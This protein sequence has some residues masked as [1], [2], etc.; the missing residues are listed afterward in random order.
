VTAPLVTVAVPVYNHAPYIEQCLDSILASS[1]TELELIIIDDASPDDS[2]A[3][4]GAW[5]DKQSRPNLTFVQH[6][7]NCGVVSTL[8]EAARLA[9]GEFFCPLASDD[10]MLPDGIRDRVAY[11][12]QHP[13]KLAV[14]ADCRVID[15]TGSPLHQS[16]IEG[17]FAEAGMRKSLLAWDDL[18]P[19]QI[20]FS[21]AVAGP[22][23]MCRRQMWEIVGPYDEQLWVEDWDMYLRL[24]ARGALGFVDATV[25]KYRVHGQ[26]M[27]GG[28]RQRTL[29][30]IAQT[31]RKHAAQFRGIQ[32]LRLLATYYHHR[33]AKSRFRR[34]LDRLLKRL[35]T[36]YTDRA[37]RRL[38]S[39]HPGGRG[40][41]RAET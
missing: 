10:L 26:S 21:W 7:Q 31:A 8:N 14:F 34:T 33:G 25:A 28:S 4:V 5:L 35:L 9:R 37:F 30:V 6:R 27:T 2:A 19:Y 41:R 24:A 12:V 20:V 39:R 18:I 15:E 11:L 23:F 17:L 32:R 1:H 38:L 29:E 22:V 40:A 13:E 16:A 36:D 3:V